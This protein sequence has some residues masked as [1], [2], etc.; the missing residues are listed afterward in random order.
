[1]Q[2]SLISKGYSVSYFENIDSVITY[3]NL[4]I[5][6]TSVGFGDSH[7][8]QCLGLY[9]NL[10]VHN[11]VF[12]PYHTT[13]NVD[14]LNIARKCLTTDVFIT[15]AN[16]LSE[17]GEIV[18]LDGTGNRIAGSLIGHKKVYFIMGKNKLVKTLDDAIWRARN[19]AAPLNA[20]RLG[21]NT[22]C[23]KDGS[24]CFNCTSTQRICNS[25]NIHLRKMNDIEME[26]VLVDKALGF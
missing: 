5:D 4:E 1:M 6:N 26:V 3:L 9:E 25:I 17:S 22:P 13:S 24:R 8:L 14:F 10:A 12:D 19:I 18:N 21:L 2:K 20:K 23:A 15:S 7:T 11:D 16:A